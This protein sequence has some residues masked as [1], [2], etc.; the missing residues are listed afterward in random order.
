MFSNT[1][2]RLMAAR[3][4]RLTF[5]SAVALGPIWWLARETPHTTSLSSWGL[6]LGWLFMPAVLAL[7]LR[8]PAARFGLVLPATVVTGAIALLT[9]EAWR[10]GA[11]SSFG[12]GVLLVGILVGDLLGVWLWS[13][14]LPVPPPLQN[15]DSA[16]RWLLIAV[17]VSL[18][19]SGLAYLVVDYVAVA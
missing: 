3:V 9:I 10:D 16:L 1:P 7:S 18:V 6:A 4:R 14:V 13:G 2:E 15:P 19:L 5:V 12:W 8:L 17:H 11:A